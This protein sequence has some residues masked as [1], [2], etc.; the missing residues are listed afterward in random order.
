MTIIVSRVLKG[1][2]TCVIFMNTAEVILGWM[3]C[4][5]GHAKNHIRFS[6]RQMIH[7][8]MSMTYKI[9]RPHQKDRDIS[10]S[11]GI[12]RIH[13]SSCAALVVGEQA[14]QQSAVTHI[15]LALSYWNFHKGRRVPSCSLNSSAA[16][17]KYLKSE[18]MHRK[19]IIVA[20]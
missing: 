14:Y 3:K 18:R 5:L 17:S 7:W 6:E 11:C 19:N 2:C 12:R 15:H 20:V 1:R 10:H 9:P 13:Y 8:F 16:S 4:F